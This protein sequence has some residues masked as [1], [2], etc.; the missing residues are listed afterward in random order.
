MSSA[1]DGRRG[2][3]SRAV[4]T[5]AAA[6]VAAYLIVR[7]LSP[8]VSTLVV[9]GAVY[10]IFAPLCAWLERRRVPRL[11]SV[12]L[13]VLL[14]GGAVVVV[15]I[16]LVPRLYAQLEDFAVSLPAHL[17]AV[18]RRL[19]EGGFLGEGA[20][21]RVLRAT[22]ALIDRA[23]SLVSGGLQ[24][25]LGFAA[26]AFGS[27]TTVILGL[28]LGFYLLHGA[29]D[30]A[31]GLAGWVPPDDRDRW[32]R[33]GRELSRAVGGFVRARVLAALFIGVSYLLAF[34]LLGLE[35]ALL[36][37]VAAGLFDLVPVIGPLLAAVPALIVAAFHSF[38]QLLA[39]VAIMLVAQQ[40]E[41]NVLEPVLAGRMVH[42]SP[43]VMVLAVA[44][45]SAAAGIPGMLVAVPLAAGL[46]SA[47]AVFYR[48]RWEEPSR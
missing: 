23:G 9:G 18:E 8:L 11:A 47:L 25:I 17:A 15:A 14:C 40:V 13:L 38:G 24:R 34:T 29:P 48:E 43:A 3:G 21:P 19:A 31:R 5:I 12:L 39:V 30:A 2:R 6:M 42:L 26:S 20:D 33:F 36:L 35:Q 10:Y 4:A 7:Y 27:I 16:T 46:R 37:G 1:E 41:S 44:A 28:A 45:G 32:V 22:D